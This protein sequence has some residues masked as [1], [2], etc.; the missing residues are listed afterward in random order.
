MLTL[1]K[2]ILTKVSFDKALFAKELKKSF[3]WLKKEQIE[4]LKMWCYEK[5]YGMYPEVIKAAF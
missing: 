4:E 1:T 5:Y 3:K 2:T